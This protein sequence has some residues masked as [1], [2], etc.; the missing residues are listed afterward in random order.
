MVGNKR[1]ENNASK[2][3]TS[4]IS[5][6]EDKGRNDA[7]KMK[8]SG[9][10]PP[11]P[12][13]SDL[14][15]FSNT[16]PNPQSLISPVHGASSTQSEAT[17]VNNILQM[18]RQRELLSLHRQQ[19]FDDF[20][21]SPEPGLRDDKAYG[22]VQESA[23]RESENQVG[24]TRKE[25]SPVPSNDISET[26]LSLSTDFHG[27]LKKQ[28]VIQQFL[29]QHTHNQQ[30]ELLRQQEQQFQRQ[31]QQN[32][33]QS[34]LHQI[35]T[36]HHRR[37]QSH[38]QPSQHS[39]E[40]PRRR[41]EHH[42]QPLTNIFP[43]WPPA[44]QLLQA[45]NHMHHA[46]YATAS[47]G[48]RSHE[49]GPKSDSNSEI[50]NLQ[51]LMRLQQLQQNPMLTLGQSNHNST[52]SSLMGLVSST[53]SGL[54]PGLLAQL[55][56]LNHTNRN[57]AQSDQ[58]ASD[59]SALIN[60]QSLLGYTN[61]AASGGGNLRGGS[62]NRN[63]LFNHGNGVVGNSA[64]ADGTHSPR[65]LPQHSGVSEAMAL[66]HAIQRDNGSTQHRFGGPDHQG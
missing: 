37:E 50:L 3:K 55:E 29:N 16:N 44:S 61:G 26:L 7:V 15:Q 54:S 60:A 42:P 4:E 21:R 52:L 62:V 40:D 32:P 41:L 43:S 34:A 6:K 22:R 66:L 1:S 30:L 48:T 31:Q 10:T 23:A 63:S 45:Q 46:Q 2:S 33:P 35:L 28:E 38:K 19:E 36:R 64:R 24:A 13:A 9:R 25:A 51:R 18:Q 14:P 20:K 53:G 65:N 49:N 56:S 17:G 47:G 39:H 11:P 27:N 58:Q 57:P 59:L 5:R 12:S 8:E